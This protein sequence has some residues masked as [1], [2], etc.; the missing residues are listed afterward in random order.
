[1]PAAQQNR[2]MYVAMAGGALFLS[3]T[4]SGLG[5]ISPST[6]SSNPRRAG[7][8]DQGRRLEAVKSA[9]STLAKA[10]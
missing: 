9:P 6:I 8:K 5:F 4:S 2:S 3:D 7:L 1:M 10:T